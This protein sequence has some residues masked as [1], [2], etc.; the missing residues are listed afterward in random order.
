MHPVP[1]ETPESSPRELVPHSHT[2]ALLLE[3]ARQTFDEREYLE[4]V[5]QIEA[6]GGVSFEAAIAEIEACVRGS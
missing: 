5:R 2:P 1:S 3:W 4:G 6:T